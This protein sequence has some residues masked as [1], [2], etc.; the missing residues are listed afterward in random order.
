MPEKKPKRKL[1]RKILLSVLVL[2]ILGIGAFLLY[3]RDVAIEYPPIVRDTACLQLKRIKIGE[4]AYTYGNNWL[5]KSESGLW[6]MYI[7]GKPFERG[8]AFGRLTKELLNYQEQTFVDQIYEIVSSRSYLNLLKYF[9]AWFNRNLDK[10]IVD[11]YKEEIYGLSLS[12]SHAFYFIGSGYQRQLNYHAAH[13]IGHAL[14]G[15]NMVGCTSFSFWGQKSTDKNLVVG[16]R[17]ST[18]LNSSHA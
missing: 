14:Q 12:A 16:D 11:E 7:E 10:H 4:N 5:R 6:E 13:D 15:L 17:K 18:R 9:V 3:F 8:V 1:K 2:F